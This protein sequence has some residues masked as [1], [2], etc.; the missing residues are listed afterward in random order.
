MQSIDILAVDFLS[1]LRV[2]RSVAVAKEISQSTKYG[3][4]TTDLIE[5]ANMWGEV[6]MWETEV[7]NGAQ[8]KA[9]IHE[10]TRDRALHMVRAAH[11]GPVA[12]VRWLHEQLEIR[13]QYL[14]TYREQAA[15][16]GAI[17]QSTL[18]ALDASVKLIK[19]GRFIASVGLITGTV[20]VALYGMTLTVGGTV[21]G[22]TMIAGAYTTNALIALPVIG[23]AK[24][25]SFAVIK[26]WNNSQSAKAVSIVFEGTK[27]GVNEG[28]G[29]MGANMY[30]GKGIVAAA[31]ASRD[32]ELLIA[33]EAQREAVRLSEA[34]LGEGQ[35][36]LA[37]MQKVRIGGQSVKGAKQ[38]AAQVATQKATV[39]VEKKAFAQT[40]ATA[41]QTAEQLALRQAARA[42]WLRIWGRRVVGGSTA[43]FAV[44]DTYDAFAELG[45]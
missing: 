32:G 6:G 22:G 7:P 18:N 12:L 33:Q 3:W 31:S 30:N 40:T 19:A 8:L 1:T 44:W 14:S 34:K 24:S 15:T 45:E 11:E 17:N 29:R 25:V 2:L 38:R 43:A 21:A 9:A 23:L 27:A 26:D 37:R 16:F 10:A 4:R 28:T 20:A 39:E 13:D 5:S 41:T 42:Q 35:A 36:K